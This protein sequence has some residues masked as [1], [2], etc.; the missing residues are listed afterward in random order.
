MRKLIE[1][2]LKLSKCTP[3]I[4]SQVYSPACCIAAAAVTVRLFRDAGHEAHAVPVDVAFLSQE[5]LILER[6][7]GRFPTANEAKGASAAHVL[8]GTGKAPAGAWA[9]HLVAVVENRLLVDFATG[10]ASDL[11]AGFNSPPFV[12]LPV[13]D[14]W[15]S[16]RSGSSLDLD[17]G[18]EVRYQYRPDLNGT[19][20][21]AEMWQ[22]QKSHEEVVNRI[23]KELRTTATPEQ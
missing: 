4:L 21:D 12:L 23:R 6:E 5:F 17:Y 11:A 2:S 1:Q 9:G 14:Q 8:I 16:A 18:W 13:D 22:N 15:L 19:W 10:Q 20:E 7:L 3:Q